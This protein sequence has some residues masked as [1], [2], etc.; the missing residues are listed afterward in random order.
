MRIFKIKFSIGGAKR[1]R[2]KWRM[3]FGIL[4]NSIFEIQKRTKIKLQFSV[5]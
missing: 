5:N 4:K 3:Q 2:E 1:R